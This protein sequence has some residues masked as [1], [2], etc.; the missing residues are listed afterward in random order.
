MSKKT[1]I[2]EKK[3]IGGDGKHVNEMRL[4]IHVETSFFSMS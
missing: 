2:D 3:P 1:C 4:S